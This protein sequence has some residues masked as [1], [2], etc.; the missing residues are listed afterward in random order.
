MASIVDVVRRQPYNI[1]MNTQRI[2]LVFAVVLAMFHACESGTE[3]N[4]R[5]AGGVGGGS[6]TGGGQAGGGMNGSGG[7]QAGG[8]M[9]GAGG[10]M[11]GSGGGQ[12]GGGVGAVDAGVP[13]A[14]QPQVYGNPLEGNPKA[15]KVDGR[16]GFDS[17][18]PLWIASGGYLLFSDV[19]NAKIWKLDPAQAPAQRFSEFTYRAGVKTNGLALNA[20]G[21]LLVCERELGSLSKV[22]LSGGTPMS[23]VSM[24]QQKPLKAP[25]D[26]VV[27]RNG[28]IYLSDPIWGSATGSTLPASAYR[29]MPSGA[30]ER[31][32]QDGKGPGNPNGIAL[33]P[34]EQTLYVT[35]DM[36]GKVWKYAVDAAGATSAEATFVT[37]PAP[38][39]IA[40]DNAGNVYVASNSGTRAIVVFR[41]NGTKIGQIDLPGQPSNA[42]FGGADLKTLYITVPNDGIYSV[43]LGVPGIP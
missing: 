21:E 16:G 28:S 20:A 15:S 24:F 43:K 2:A 26:V 10:G 41:P 32:T 27:G 39:G 19:N 1:S 17:E 18:G 6:S 30:V 11:M 35:D 25:N 7:G 33:S 23:V 42:S 4:G 38:D 22:P 3:P 34:D 13:D 40:I 12:A 8:G 31:I 36:G 29:I 5:D 14:G 37:V 9:I